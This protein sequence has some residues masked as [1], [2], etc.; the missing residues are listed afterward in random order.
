MHKLSPVMHAFT[1]VLIIFSLMLCLL[2]IITPIEYIYHGILVLSMYITFE[3][4]SMRLLFAVMLGSTANMWGLS[5]PC[6]SKQ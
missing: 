5:H 3:K 2:C 4:D 6:D 1:G